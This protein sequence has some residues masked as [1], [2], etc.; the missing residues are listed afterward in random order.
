MEVYHDNLDELKSAEQTI[1]ISKDIKL[2]TNFVD[3]LD[4]D[5]DL[6]KNTARGWGCIFIIKRKPNHHAE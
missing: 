3:E 4:L 2:I 1:Q 5:N 6:F